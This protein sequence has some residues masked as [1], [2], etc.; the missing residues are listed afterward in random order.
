[1]K[2]LKLTL[3]LTVIFSLNGLAQDLFPV[4]FRV[5]KQSMSTPMTTLEESFFMHSYYARPVNIEFD[6]KLLKMYFD[7]KVSLI[8]EGVTAV[9][10]EVESE[11]NDVLLEKYYFTL[12]SNVSDTVMFVVDYEVPYLQVVLPTKN[13]SGE[14]VGYTS[15]KEFIDTEKLAVN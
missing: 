9:N 4:K 7:N 13:N 12:N 14:Y 11:G 5:E 3:L 6:G 15:Y 1:M 8:N 10:K 2:I